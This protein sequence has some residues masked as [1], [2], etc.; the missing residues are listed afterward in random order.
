[1]SG[2]YAEWNGQCQR[3][4]KSVSYCLLHLSNS[5]HLQFPHKVEASCRRR[6]AGFGMFCR[7]SGICSWQSTDVGCSILETATE[8]TYVQVRHLSF[9]VSLC[10]F[11]SI[12]LTILYD[13]KILTSNSPFLFRVDDNEIA[14][15]FQLPNVLSRLFK[16]ASDL[17]GIKIKVSF[18]SMQ[19][20]VLGQ[21]LFNHQGKAQN[22]SI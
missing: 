22:L 13:V 14:E 8:R 7:F 6:D 15:Y 2:D 5:N 11:M 9:C 21:F 3:K 12:V 17:F 20:L 10:P 16:F 18:W 19:V 4:W 1:M